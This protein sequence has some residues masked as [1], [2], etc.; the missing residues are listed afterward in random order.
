MEAHVALVDTE[1]FTTP[2]RI[3][4][5][6]SWL[7]VEGNLRCEHGILMTDIQLFKMQT[8]TEQVGG[9]FQRQQVG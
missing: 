3:S 5:D 9:P 8:K 2:L 1:D 6:I 7:G 4:W